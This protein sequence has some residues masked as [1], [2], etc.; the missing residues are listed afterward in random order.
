MSSH[1]S[2]R[3]SQGRGISASEHVLCI[4][5]RGLSEYSFI[6]LLSFW[7]AS[8]PYRIQNPSRPKVPPNYWKDTHPLPRPPP[9]KTGK[10]VRN[11]ATLVAWFARIGNSSDSCESALR[12]MKTGVSFARIDSRE[13][14]RANRVANCPCT[15][16]A[17]IS[18][19]LQLLHFVCIFSCWSGENHL[20]IISTNCDSH[21]AHI[22]P[23]RDSKRPRSLFC[24]WGCTPDPRPGPTWA[25]V[26]VPSRVRRGPVQIRHVLCLQ[27]FGPIQVPRWGPSRPVL[28]PSWSRASFQDRPGWAETDF[29]AASDRVLNTISTSLRG[30][31]YLD[32]TQIQNCPAAMFDP[33]HWKKGK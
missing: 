4:C 1:L 24:F 6:L 26:Q 25:R 29:F 27:H 16:S 2:R 18:R 13:S 22:L 5:L 14:I 15:K 9:Q 11:S 10:N 31:G 17:T 12:A 32:T 30:K 33:R 21:S 20:P 19:K 7:I 23:S 8:S 28:V 3:G